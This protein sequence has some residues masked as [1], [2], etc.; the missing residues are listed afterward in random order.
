MLRISKLTDYGTLILAQLP[1]TGRGLASAGQVASSTHL[2]HPTVS[3]LLKALVRAG[4][5]VSARGAQGG[6]A[7]ARPAQDI[8]AAQIIDALEGPVAITECSAATGHCGLEPVCRVGHAWKK[9]NVG[10]REALAQVSLAD[11][12]HRGDPLRTPDLRHALR[13]GADKSGETALRS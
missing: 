10:I 12:Q 11:L 5:V 3:K 6:Y 1:V 4:L 9:I 13:P 8:T 2:A 7:L